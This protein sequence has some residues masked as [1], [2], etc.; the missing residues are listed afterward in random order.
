M[1]LDGAG[2]ILLWL[3]EGGK[4]GNTFGDEQLKYP[5]VFSNWQS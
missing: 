3:I 4:Q 1:M 2:K 5:F